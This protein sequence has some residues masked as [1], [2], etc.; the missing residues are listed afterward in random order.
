MYILSMIKPREEILFDIYPKEKR[1]RIEQLYKALLDKEIGCWPDVTTLPKQ[2]RQ[3]LSEN[4]PYFYFHNFDTITDKESFSFKARITLL[5]NK[6]IESVLMGSKTRG[7]TACLSTQVG[8]AIGC[9]FCATG[10][11]GFSRNLL[12]DEIIDQ[13]RLWQ[14]FIKDNRLR[15]T[16]TNIVFMGMGEPLLNYENTR[17]AI[18]IILNNAEIYKKHITVSTIGIIEN[19]NKML[20]DKKWPDVK[21][22]LSVQS[23]DLKTRKI[24]VPSTKDSYFTDL[25]NWIQKYFKKYNQRSRFI[26]I[27]YVIIDNINDSIDEAKKLANFTKNIAKVK[28]NIIPYNQAS[29]SFKKPQSQKIEQFK[30]FLEN[31]NITVTLR[32]SKGES[33]LAACGQLIT[34]GQ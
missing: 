25:I 19:L 32:K 3:R 33:I 15:N 26:T 6:K 22:A 29:T 12:A 16:I 18:N 27:E 11:M 20:S 1:Y 23:A 34:S 8:C 28:I 7:F 17:D 9:L 5:D 14:K 21:I 4:M 10:K 31:R 2:M 24:L 13:L 30:S